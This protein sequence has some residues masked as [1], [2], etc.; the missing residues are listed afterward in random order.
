MESATPAVETWYTLQSELLALVNTA[1]LAS[2]Q[3]ERL[4]LLT[5]IDNVLLLLTM[6]VHCAVILQS[7]L[8]ALVNTA[9]LASMQAERLEVLDAEVAQLQKVLV[10]VGQHIKSGAQQ[11]QVRTAA[12]QLAGG[13]AVYVLL[14]G[15]GA[16]LIDASAK[17]AAK[18]S[19]NI[20]V[21]G[22]G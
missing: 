18:L 5:S 2:M 16:A 19:A 12:G 9:K 14:A 15:A 3:A 13:S 20:A 7:E 10:R 6:A 4:E 1:K 8:L 21:V 11:Q 17:P 22:Y